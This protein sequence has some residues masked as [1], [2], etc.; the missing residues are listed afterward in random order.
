MAYAY[1]EEDEGILSRCRNSHHRLTGHFVRE[2]GTTQG[3]P[4]ALSRG[5]EQEGLT[6][7]LLVNSEVAD[8][9]DTGREG[10][11]KQEKVPEF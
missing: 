5:R 9:I 11:C 6:Y 4:M 7:L 1:L 8:D 10:K 3:P 2:A